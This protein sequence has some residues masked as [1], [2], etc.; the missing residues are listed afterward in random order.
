MGEI[1]NNTLAMLVGVA[2]LLTL[3]AVLTPR[4]PVYITGRATDVGIARVNISK[5]VAINFTDDIIDW[6]TGYVAEGADSCTLD[7]EGNVGATC[8]GFTAQSNGFTI[9]NIGNRRVVLQLKTGKDAT[10]FINGTNPVYQYKVSEAEAGACGGTLQPTTYTDVNVTDPG[11]T[12]CDN[13]L[14]QNSKD[15]LDIDVK[16]VI[17]SDSNVGLLTDTFTATATEAT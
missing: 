9:E 6:G 14:F 10:E 13:F 2:I 5:F 7:T 17:P 8:V 11:T 1:S 4:G 16:I 15:S 12:I 3:I